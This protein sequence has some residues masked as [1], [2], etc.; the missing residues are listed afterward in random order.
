MLGT[1]AKQDLL[2]HAHSQLPEQ[3]NSV[4][5]NMGEGTTLAAGFCSQKLPFSFSLISLMSG[6]PQH[7]G[8]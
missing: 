5:G 8:G 3:P 7:Q 1:P 4:C 2:P 6:P